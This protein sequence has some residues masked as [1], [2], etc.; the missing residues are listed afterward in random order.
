[1]RKD[2]LIKLADF[3]IATYLLPDGTTVD[4]LA[5]AGLISGTPQYISPEQ[6]ST[7]AQIDFRADIYSLGR[8]FITPRPDIRRLISVRLMSC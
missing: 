3:G 2:G 1:M 7:P 8:R 4:E 6:I 5:R